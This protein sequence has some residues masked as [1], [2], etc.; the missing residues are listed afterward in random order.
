MVYPLFEFYFDQITQKYELDLPISILTS[1][2]LKQFY[3]GSTRHYHSLNH[4]EDCLRQLSEYEFSLEKSKC[5]ID[6]I[7]L[8]II[9]HDSIYIPTASDNEE[10]SALLMETVMWRSLMEVSNITL[11]K[12]MILATKHKEFNPIANYNINTQL[13]LDID[14]SSLGYDREKFNKNNNDI[15]SE[16]SFISNKQFYTGRVK[17]LSEL[18]AWERLY[19]TDYFYEKYEKRAR[20]NIENEIKQIKLISEK[21]NMLQSFVDGDMVTVIQQPDDVEIDYVED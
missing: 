3:A 12:A 11:V 14:L 7:A 17:F 8:G 19:Y 1:A 13:L 9:F 20:E 15:R 21:E 5:D 18:L 2:L 10:S 4:I 16:Y 6:L